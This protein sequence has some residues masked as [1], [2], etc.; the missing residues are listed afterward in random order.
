MPSPQ[1]NAPDAPPRLAVHEL[2]S[3]LA[4]PFELELAPGACAAITGESGSG[5]SL[6]LRMIADL[7]P[8]EG[9]VRLDG[10]P[11]SRFAPPEWR[12]RVTY[13]AAEAGWWLDRVSE[14]IRKPDL[15]KARELAGRLGLAPD[16]VDAEV[17]R[18]S[19][20]EKQRFA[21]IRALL[22]DPPVLL[23]DEPTGALDQGSTERVE[24]LLRDRLKQGRSLIM[25]THDE[26]LAERLATSRFRMENR[27]M[28]PL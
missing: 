28:S 22:L 8:N 19:T 1:P 10:E 20:G 24:Q 13:V 15:D 12:K 9:E 6:F 17:A 21:I 26:A 7:D 2:R 23:L 27:R 3:P 18:L 14:H 5:K 11:R 4:G 25:V 16:L